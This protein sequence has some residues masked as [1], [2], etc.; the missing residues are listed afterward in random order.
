MY[1]QQP[2]PKEYQSQSVADAV[3][4]K[5]SAR[6]KGIELVDNRFKKSIQQKSI[7]SI[8]KKENTISTQQNLGNQIVQRIPFW[9]KELTGV[10]VV[11]GAI[12]GGVGLATSTP[13]LAL[14]G[15]A[16]L[17]GGAGYAT[18]K[19]YHH[20][21]RRNTLN[22]MV[23]QID[24]FAPGANPN[25]AL[26]PNALGRSQIA[27]V[28][29]PGALNTDPAGPLAGRQY[30]IDINPNNPTG[31][32]VSDP[33]IIRSA[34]LHEQTHVAND[35]LYNANANRTHDTNIYNATNLEMNANPEIDEVVYQRVTNLM[36]TVTNDK[37]VPNNLKGY[38]KNRLDYILGGANPFIEYDTV[39]NELL[40]F[41]TAK[42]IEADSPTMQEIT[43]MASENIVRR[44]G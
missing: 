7:Q 43:K 18:Y 6:E 32:H 5:M 30:R 41:M 1:T 17:L 31:E 20:I 42:H 36:K 28:K 27:L 23:N 33:D 22:R 13:L 26:N 25:V 38:I 39:V 16:A 11:G 21:K 15:G 19:G 3:A 8:Q 40:Y 35:Q 9:K 2:N 4:Q 44:G 14:A 12:A 29:P 10:S 24:Q 34:M 37:Q